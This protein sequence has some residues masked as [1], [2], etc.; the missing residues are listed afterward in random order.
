MKKRSLVALVL[1]IIMITSVVT[2]CGTDTPIIGGLIGLDSDQI[3]EV[4]EI[5]CSDTEYKLVL[6][7][8]Q[9]LY[10]E[11]L[12]TITD[13][14][15]EVDEG[16]TLGEFIKEKTKEDITVK[17]T[18]AAMATQKGI[19]LTTEEEAA[20]IEA[21]GIYYSSLTEAEKEYTGASQSDVE[22]VYTNYLLAE[23]VYAQLTDPIGTSITDEEARVIKIQYI[24][25][26]SENTK[27][28]KINNI[29]QDVTSLVNGGYQEFSREA[30]QYSEDSTIEKIIKKN[31]AT[32]PYEVAAF[33]LETGEISNII[34][35]GNNYYLVYCVSSYLEEETTNNKDSIVEKEKKTYFNEEY[36]KYVKDVDTDFNTSAW[37]DI[38]L[39]TDANITNTSLIVEFDKIM[40]E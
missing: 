19:A 5:I 22:K 15:V 29:Y 40:A 12:G 10:E 20:I 9:N 21:A 17:Y 4:D 28:T 34:Q 1:S 36:N 2:G 31:E 13:W 37:E 39:T 7:N 16:Y 35:D 8:T 6:M 18:L 26:N 14:S 33:E 3:F 24:R 27:E 38:D 30:K 23:K 32:A 11:S 25:I